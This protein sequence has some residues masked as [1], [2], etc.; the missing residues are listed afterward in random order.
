M[1]K[2]KKSGVCFE[3]AAKGS[4]RFGDRCW[5]SHSGTAGEGIIKARQ[6]FLLTASILAIALALAIITDMKVLAFRAGRQTTGAAATSK[7]SEQATPGR[8]Y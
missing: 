6:L 2:S 5:F 8:P 1:G 7:D 4:C 3:Y